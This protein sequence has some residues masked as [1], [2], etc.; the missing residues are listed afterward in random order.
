MT[1]CPEGTDGAGV[2]VDADGLVF[3]PPTPVDAGTGVAGVES[4]SEDVATGAEMACS[5]NMTAGALGGVSGGGA[6]EVGEDSDVTCVGITGWGTTPL[7]RRMVASVKGGVAVVMVT[8][9][10]RIPVPFGVNVNWGAQ[11]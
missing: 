11:P 9:A 2:L 3:S 8:I 5:P 4:V 6:V 7:P 1:V 10:C